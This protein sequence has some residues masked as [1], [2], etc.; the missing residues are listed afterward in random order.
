MSAGSLFDHD[1]KSG[2]GKSIYLIAV[3]AFLV[4]AG[5]GYGFYWY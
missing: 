3:L 1:T 2:P 4:L 5:A